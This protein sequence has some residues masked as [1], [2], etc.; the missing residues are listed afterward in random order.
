MRLLGLEVGRA[1]FL[2]L[3]VVG[4]HP[5]D[6]EVFGVDRAVAVHVGD[7]ILRERPLT[8]FP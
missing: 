7:G 4:G 8:A 6:V 3:E 5:D 1:V 2:V